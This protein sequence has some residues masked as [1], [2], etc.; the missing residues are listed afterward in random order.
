MKK[1]TPAEAWQRIAATSLKKQKAKAKANT[2]ANTAQSVTPFG[3]DYVEGIYVFHKDDGEAIIA[4]AFESAI[5]I[6]GKTSKAASSTRMPPALLEW[7]DALNTEIEL[8]EATSQSSADITPN[9]PQP[10]SA[11]SPQSPS[12]SSPQ[13]PAVSPSG[14][15]AS[16]SK[17]PA[18]APASTPA[19]KSIAPLVKAKWSQFEPFNANLIIGGK[20][21]AT[22]CCAT[23]AAQLL[24]YWGCQ[25]HD[26][27]YY[28]R[29]CMATK[30][31]KTETNKDKVEALPPIKVFDYAHLTAKKPTS[32]ASKAAAASLLEY[33]GKA[34]YSD[35]GRLS[36]SAYISQ[37][38]HALQDKFRMGKPK[39]YYA[40]QLSNERL[41]E[42]IYSNLAQGMPVILAGRSDDGAH[43][44]ICDGYDKDSG[45]FHFNWGWGGSYDGYY[46][47]SA[48][49]PMPKESYSPTVLI[50]NINPEYML[51]DVNGDG[52]ISVQDVFDTV[53]AAFNGSA[54]TRADIDS[55]GQVTISDAQAIANHITG[56]DR[57]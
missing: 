40:Y 41:A 15:Q 21:C 11:S 45:M 28:H 38:Y 48:L 44:F 35:Y 25:P 13:F 56:K 10:T 12:A 19:R 23:A 33:V 34:I 36:T 9:T 14:S 32:K 57:L 37:I 3:T 51:G 6:I 4:S 49:A 43:C 20:A 2:Q 17:T 7:I 46:A 5:P 30:A 53:Q 55:D 18:K 31:Y 54:N 27:K 16:P 8:S 42:I 24:Y 52:E 26:G 47:I 29:G 50:S 22:G 39:F 1:L